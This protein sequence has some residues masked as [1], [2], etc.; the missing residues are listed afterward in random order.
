MVEK[1]ESLCIQLMHA[2]V[3]RGHRQL[4]LVLLLLLL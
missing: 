4:T 2:Y 3:I 1:H